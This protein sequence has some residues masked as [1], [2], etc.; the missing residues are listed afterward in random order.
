MFHFRIFFRVAALH[1]DPLA[2]RRHLRSAYFKISHSFFILRRLFVFY[3]IF[4][5]L[6]MFFTPFIVPLLIL[7]LFAHIHHYPSF[8]F[9]ALF[10][11]DIAFRSYTLRFSSRT[12][13][14]SLGHRTTHFV[15]ALPS[16][17]PRHPPHLV[18]N[19]RLIPLCSHD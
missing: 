1:P 2:S 7:P 15:I 9:T 4:A 6:F 5:A 8:I 18:A 14:A 3:F 16:E 19:S 17:Y 12:R 13:A 10:I 11:S